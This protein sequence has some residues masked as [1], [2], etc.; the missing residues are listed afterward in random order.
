MKA[1]LE[2]LGNSVLWHEKNI[3]DTRKLVF[4]KTYYVN[5]K[6][7][8]MKYTLIIITCSGRIFYSGYQSATV[9]SLLIAWGPKYHNRILNQAVWRPIS[10]FIGATNFISLAFLFDRRQHIPDSSLLHNFMEGYCDKILI[11]LS[12]PNQ[13]AGFEDFDS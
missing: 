2:M 11:E 12:N 3:S 6:I 5:N 9:S 10:N 1:V 13:D 7:S 8:R 4:E